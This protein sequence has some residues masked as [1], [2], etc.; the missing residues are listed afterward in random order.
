MKLIK[1]FFILFLVNFSISSKLSRNL[2]KMREFVCE[3][4]KSEKVIT[5][6]MKTIVVVV[7]ENFF[8]KNFPNDIMTCLPRNVAKVVIDSFESE[9]MNASFH[10]SSLVVYISDVFEKVRKEFV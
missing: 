5:K 2:D 7:D 4:A 1:V 6:E 8:P 9:Q 3:V 10:K